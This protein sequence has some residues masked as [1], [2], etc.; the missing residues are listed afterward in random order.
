MARYTLKEAAE[1]TRRSVTTLRRYIRSGRLRAEKTSGR[2]GP[3]YTL[4]EECLVAAGFEIHSPPRL[5]VDETSPS[6]APDSSH[7]PL[8]AEEALPADRALSRPIEKVLVDFVPADLYRELSMKHEQLLVQY[9]MIRASG[10]KLFEYR[11]EADRRSEE[12][13]NSEERLKEF[14]DRF[15]REVGFLKRHLRQ[16][17]LEIEERNIEVSQLREKIRLL[18]LLTRNQITNETIEKQFLQIFQKERELD[19]LLSGG[20]RTSNDS[21]GEPSEESRGGEAL[22]GH[23]EVPDRAQQ[24]LEALNRWLD[25]RLRD[26][27]EPDQADH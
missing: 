10:Q 6:D 1:L 9:G 24:G 4:D 21:A 25:S 14:Q 19:A 23:G 17:E 16:A 7:L 2:F 12:L 3:E 15:S 22:L 5:G 27:S 11:D 18:E 20:D 26:P 13:R 8:R